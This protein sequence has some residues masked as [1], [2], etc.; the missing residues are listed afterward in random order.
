MFIF[1]NHV[2][3]HLLSAWQFMR[4][5]C[6]CVHHCFEPY[7]I[8]Q[9]SQL[10]TSVKSVTMCLKWLFHWWWCSQPSNTDN[11]D[12]IVF[13][14]LILLC[15]WLENDTYCQLEYSCVVAL[16]GLLFRS[17][18]ASTVRAW[19]IVHLADCSD[20]RLFRWWEQPMLRPMS[21][22]TD[23]LLNKP[24]VAIWLWTQLYQHHTRAWP[25]AHLPDVP[26]ANCENSECYRLST[27]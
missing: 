11:T 14:I 13:Q 5:I 16:V 3:C 19:P 15:I 1:S 7:D 12:Q 24:N 23:C 18:G 2:K 17:F 6:C 27:E 25:M 4:I 22:V 21:S 10:Q 26:I 20:G 8:A 9:D